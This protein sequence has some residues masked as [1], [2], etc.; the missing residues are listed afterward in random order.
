MSVSLTSLLACKRWHTMHISIVPESK[1]ITTHHSR[2][3]QR[4][5]TNG[6]PG[7]PLVEGWWADWI[8]LKPTLARLDGDS[9][10][11]PLRRLGR[12]R[13]F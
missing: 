4:L 10:I 2:P 13:W 7:K 12:K 6:S 5:E 11:N 9:S 3:D 1:L 8:Y